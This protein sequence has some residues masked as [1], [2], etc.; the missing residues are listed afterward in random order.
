[1]TP[2]HKT[3]I[4]SSAPRI[5]YL[6]AYDS[7][8]NNIIGLLETRLA[9][10][11]TVIRVDDKLANQDFTKIVGS[12][13]AIVVG[14]GPGHPANDNDVGLINKVWDLEAEHL[15]PVLGICLGF[16]SLAYAFG[17]NIGRLR[18]ARHGIVSKITHNGQDVFN[19]I[20]TLQA[21]QYHSLFVDLGHDKAAHEG[22]LWNATSKCHDLVPLAWDCEDCGNGPILMAHRHVTKPFWGVQFHPESICTNVEGI[23]L[24]ENWWRAAR[25]WLTLS[26]RGTKPLLANCLGARVSG[27]STVPSL[28]DK[29]STAGR[30]GP[31]YMD[32]SVGERSILQWKRL[33]L[34]ECSPTEL[35]ERLRLQ[36]DEVVLLDSQGHQTGRYSIVGVVSSGSTIKLTYD[37]S[38]RNISWVLPGGS[39]LDLQLETGTDIWEILRASLKCPTPSSGCNGLPLESPFWGGWMGYISYEAGLETIA[40]DIPEMSSST[41]GSDFNLAFIKRSLVIDHVEDHL[42]I[43]S[44]ESEDDCW[45]QEIERIL[46]SGVIKA[47]KVRRRSNERSPISRPQTTGASRDE[48]ALAMHLKNAVIQKPDESTYRANVLECQRSL[49]AGESYELCYTDETRI[50]I[51]TDMK[52]WS[53][54]KRLRKENAAPFGAF[55]RLTGAT[56]V[57]SSPERF[58][59]WDR[60]GNCQFRPIKGTVRKTAEMTYEK[61]NAILSTSKERAENLMIVDLIRHDLSGV[62]GAQN[63]RVTKLMQM[64]EYQTLYQLVSVIEGRPPK[65][66]LMSAPL[67]ERDANVQTRKSDKKATSSPL[68]IQG[69][70]VLKASLP[71]G[72]MTGAPKKRSCEILAKLEKRPRSIYSGVLG[73]MDVGGGGDFSVVIRTAFRYDDEVVDRPLEQENST[74]ETSLVPHHVWRIGAGGAVTVQSTDKG[75]YDEMETKLDSV[76][77]TFQL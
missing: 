47:E 5:L 19:G 30:N 44:L 21:T 16:Q 68:E 25:T 36:E 73:Y 35:I 28:A 63:C 15:L 31:S 60:E 64:E 6:D 23:R 55:L 38:N 65:P 45:F 8:A 9:A 54:Y 10:N 2:I 41:H 56:V 71:P 72:S 27:L 17:A 66:P 43:Q 57:G 1:M 26:Q 18:K 50:L 20:G 52:A 48:A 61:A 34:S 33:S 7:F 67:A 11:V 59:S 74:V 29:L 4:G 24:L 3:Q 49:S 42:Y 75:E 13:D 32:H 12:F 22:E 39:K 70:D 51:P 69:L 58:L 46:R 37:V 40:V 77:K 62:V 14:P 76:L 53:L